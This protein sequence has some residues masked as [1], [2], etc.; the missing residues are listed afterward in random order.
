MVRSSWDIVVCA[1][2]NV[3]STVDYLSWLVLIRT[4]LVT[5]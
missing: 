3:S 1:L 2:V 5:Q 4:G